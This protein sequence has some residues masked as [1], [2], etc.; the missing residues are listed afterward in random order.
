[1]FCA[2][3]GDKG[4]EY[5]LCPLVGHQGLSSGEHFDP[6]F[7]R[8]GQAARR[9]R[10]DETPNLPGIDPLVLANAYEAPGAD[11]LALVNRHPFVSSLAAHTL[12]A[13]SWTIPDPG[14]RAGSDA[15]RRILRCAVERDSVKFRRFSLPNFAPRNILVSGGDQVPLLS[16]LGR[17]VSGR[18]GKTALHDA[19]QFLC[20]HVFD[21]SIDGNAVAIG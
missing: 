4:G 9:F 16:N 17:C 18:E 15:A 14:E 19:V 6:F 10:K 3:R 11:P 13:F 7:V 1:V 5:G 2:S 12:L 21:G 8:A 20:Q